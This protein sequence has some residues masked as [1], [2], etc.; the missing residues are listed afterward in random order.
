[1]VVWM[2]EATQIAGCTILN[3]LESAQVSEP[4]SQ[5]SFAKKNYKNSEISVFTTTLTAMFA[6]QTEQKSIDSFF[7][8]NAYVNSASE[9]SS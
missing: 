5:L 6:R 7:L 2:T 4:N 1:M 3:Y 9:I 8:M